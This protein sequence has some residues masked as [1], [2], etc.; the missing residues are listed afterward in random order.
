MSLLSL[1]FWENISREEAENLLKK[2]SDEFIYLLRSSSTQSGKL[3]ITIKLD[4]SYFIHY[5]IIMEDGKYSFNFDGS[6]C[7]NSLEE[8]IMF[9]KTYEFTIRGKT[10]KL[11]HPLINGK[12][13]NL[14]NHYIIEKKQ[15]K[16]TIV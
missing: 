16:E 10:F 5:R 4:R 14:E 8:L 7:Y 9:L 13:I 1:G 6:E 11:S 3:V 15:R 2:N 12:K